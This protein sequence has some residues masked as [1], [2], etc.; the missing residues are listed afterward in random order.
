MALDAT[1]P[2][3]TALTTFFDNGI[4]LN[5][6]A[7]GVPTNKIAEMRT[8]VNNLISA[9]CSALIGEITANGVTNVTDAVNSIV[10]AIQGGVPVA[11]DGGAALKA[12]IVA[13]LPSTVSGKI[14]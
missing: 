3:N 9:I 6:I 14:S 5:L 10:S 11:M 4:K 7:A 13:A 2:T 1:R 12:S 8:D